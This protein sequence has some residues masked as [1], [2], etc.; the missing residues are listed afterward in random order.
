M[1]Q[2]PGCRECG[3][4]WFNYY[5]GLCRVC[6]KAANGFPVGTSNEVLPARD[7]MTATT[8]LKWEVTS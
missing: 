1:G 4:A 3:G 6:W 8:T 2:N 7:K 5:G